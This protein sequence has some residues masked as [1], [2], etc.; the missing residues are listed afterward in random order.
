MFRV[1]IDQLG[2]IFRKGE[3]NNFYYMLGM[4]RKDTGNIYRYVGEI[5]WTNARRKKNE[6]RKQWKFFNASSLLLDK[7]YFGALLETLG[8]KNL[9]SG[10]LSMTVES[11]ILIQKRKWIFI[12]FFLSRTL[13]ISLKERQV[14][15]ERM[16]I[17]LL[18]DFMTGNCIY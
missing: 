12:P 17:I 15:E 13:N 9:I 1:F 5:T 3:L 18:S 2:W 10:I 4:D 7:M 8:Y 6:V 11:G 14:E 16:W